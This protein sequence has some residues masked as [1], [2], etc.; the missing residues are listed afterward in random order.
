VPILMAWIFVSCL[1]STRP[2][3]SFRYSLY[4]AGIVAFGYWMAIRFELRDIIV[5][6]AVGF[7][8]FLVTQAVTIVLLPAYSIGGEGWAGTLSNKNSFG[9]QASMSV[10]L[11]VLAARLDRRR[12]A[13]WWLA[14]VAALTMAI[15]SESKTAL[16]AVCGMPIMAAI[17]SS[18]RARRTLYGAVA[19]TL[20]FGSVVAIWFGLVKRPEIAAALGKDPNLT[21]R[22]ALWKAIL[23]ELG[24]RP[25]TGFGIEGFWLPTW[26]GPQAIIWKRTFTAPHSHNGLFQYWLDLGAVGAG[27]MLAIT[28]RTIV[29]GARVLRWYRG[30]DGLFPLLYIVLTVLVSVSEPGILLRDSILLFLPVAAVAAARGRRDVLRH[31]YQH[32]LTTRSAVQPLTVVA[33]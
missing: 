16:L 32:H 9:R 11:I 31:Q 4:L 23:P 8:L 13:W 20:L 7:T 19:A 30:A 17:F 5:M 26:E 29:R 15:G 1:W 33:V 3:E 18:L 28:I 21:G 24:R 12:R 25:I 27:L 14:L 22:T 10:V 6:S 2:M